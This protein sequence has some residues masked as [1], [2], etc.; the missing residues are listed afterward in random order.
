M[1]GTNAPLAEGTPEEGAASIDAIG[2]IVTPQSPT[3]PPMA[4]M[5]MTGGSSEAT[6]EDASTG[7][8]TRAYMAARTMETVH[9][10][11]LADEPLLSPPE[12]RQ[13]PETGFEVW[14]EGFW[15]TIFNAGERAWGMQ[16]T[17]PEPMTLT[18]WVP[19][20]PGL[21]WKPEARRL[22]EFNQAAVEIIGNRWHAY[23]PPTKSLRV[24]G[25]V[26]TLR[27]PPADDGTHLV[28]LSTGY[29]ASEGVPALVSEEVWDKISALFPYE[30]RRIRLK[31]PV[32]WRAMSTGWDNH[33]KST[34][35]VPRGY[36]AVKDPD[37]VEVLDEVA[38]ILVQP[39]S[40]MEYR[41]DHV[42]LFDY[43][44]CQADT[45]YP[46]WRG[47][48]EQFFVDYA[49]AQERFGRYLLAADMV[50]GLW[51]AV[52]ETP[53]RLR[54]V[55]AAGDSQLALLE[56]RV[57]ERMNHDDTIDRFL[58]VLGVVCHSLGDLEIISSDIG[59]EPGAWSRGGTL[60]E[61]A[62]Q[63]MDV[64]LQR[65]KLMILADYLG[66]RFSRVV[67]N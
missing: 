61:G 30:G 67:R 20:V 24:L 6:S 58:R 32:R 22:R 35:N 8:L 21:Y 28:T 16:F 50:S 36:L 65:G 53:D 25:G 59:I 66:T 23:N 7:L 4:Q 39:F 42:E 9:N 34:S 3:M 33:F 54:S 47:Q 27:L 19:R 41:D 46:E 63:F 48:I 49:S 2:P 1:D 29:N 37:A 45:S 38:P 51:E 56:A 17:L 11:A 18:E 62:N 14:D 55:D 64:V 44:F 12:E 15:Q 5:S 60:Y 26:G 10:Y 40:V 57:N 43:V 31:S 13:T 52:Y